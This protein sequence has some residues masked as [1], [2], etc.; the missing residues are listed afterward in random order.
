MEWDLAV[1]REDGRDDSDEIFVTLN[2][3]V[4]MEPDSDPVSSIEELAGEHGMCF[5]WRFISGGIERNRGSQR[6]RQE[7]F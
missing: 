6:S 1:D 3:F 4:E 5:S 7:R 2:R